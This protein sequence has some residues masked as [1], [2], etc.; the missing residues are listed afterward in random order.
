MPKQEYV[1]YLRANG[2]SEDDIKALSE[3]SFSGASIRA[4]DAMQARLTAESSARA[5]AE[6]A[7]SD[8]DDWFQKE[9]TP[10]WNDLQTSVTR[11]RGNEARAVETLR[12]LSRRGLIENAVLEGFAPAGGDGGNGRPG[13]GAPGPDGRRSDPNPGNPNF[14]PNNYLTRDQIL[15]IARQEGEA[16]AMAQDIATEHARLF[17]DKALSFRD[18][19][20]DALSRKISVEQVW[21]EKYG[22]P[23]ARLARE[24]KSQDDHDAA[25]SKAAED[26]VRAEYAARYGANPDTRLPMPSRSPFMVRADR[27]AGSTGVPKQPWESSEG[28]LS[29]K[30]VEN[31]VK[32]SLEKTA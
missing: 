16:I 28:E 19:R 32:R 13:A 14:D 29:A 1:D 24:K 27:A 23:A 7:K 2:A 31:A 20:A 5:V 18:L 17:P 25:I 6:K 10:Q 22:V 11:A 26:R 21:L 4:F 3:G 12:E 8:Y 9:L 15:N 30:R